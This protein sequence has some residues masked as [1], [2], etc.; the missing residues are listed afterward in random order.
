MPIIL[1]M[2]FASGV[3]HCV[4][5]HYTTNQIDGPF[6]LMS[7]I[8]YSNKWRKV[9]KKFIP[10]KSIYIAQKKWKHGHVAQNYKFNYATR[11]NGNMV[12]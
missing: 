12:M 2:H 6:Y 11:E 7:C 4:L 3:H 9:S 1:P 10:Q 5:Y 8:L